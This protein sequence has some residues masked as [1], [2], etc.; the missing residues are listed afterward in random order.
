MNGNRSRNGLSLSS[1]TIG[2]DPR[3]L[4]VSSS[5]RRNDTRVFFGYFIGDCVFGL[6]P[7]RWKMRKS[8]FDSLLEWASKN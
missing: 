4:R 6:K 2:P 1:F 5:T 7:I 3:A 8:L